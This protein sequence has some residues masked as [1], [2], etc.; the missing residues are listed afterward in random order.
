M[1]KGF[2]P[3]WWQQV[4]DLGGASD[5]DSG[6][7]GAGVLDCRRGQVATAFDRRCG[8]GSQAHLAQAAL[9]EPAAAVVPA[10]RG[11]T[12]CC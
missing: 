2:Y 10:L 5:S 8:A 6:G 7:S 9:S 11:H 12:V 1:R 4:L 3:V